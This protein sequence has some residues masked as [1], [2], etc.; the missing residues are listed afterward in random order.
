M[1]KIDRL[2]LGIFQVNTYFLIDGDNNVL[3]VDPGGD[4]SEIK[5]YIEKNNLKVKMII[6]THAHP[7]H[8]EANLFMKENYPVPLLTHPEEIISETPPDRLI[9]EGDLVEFG[10]HQLKIRHT[11]GHTMGSICIEGPEFLLTGDTLFAGAIGRT[12]LG[13]DMRVM[14]ETLAQRFNDIPDETILYPGHG[15]QTTMGRER[16]ENPYLRGL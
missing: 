12:D 8:V 9:N 13:G 6:N 4:G 10:G 14:M 15:P 11:P 3:V 16:K 2:V 5:D 7:D 1:L